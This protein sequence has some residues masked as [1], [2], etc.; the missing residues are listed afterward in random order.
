MK[1]ILEFN[2]PE[3]TIEHLLALHGADYSIVCQEL[4]ERLRGWLKYG[5]E[6]KTIEE[7]LESVR[8]ELRQ[9]LEDRYITL[10]MSC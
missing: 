2:L 9:L 1:A 8:N 4:D 5:H 6:F 10:D 7:A 3:E